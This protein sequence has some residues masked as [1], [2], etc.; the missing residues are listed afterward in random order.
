M[1]AQL[2]PGP[3]RFDRSVRKL[4]K[5]SLGEWDFLNRTALDIAIELE[6][7]NRNNYWKSTS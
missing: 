6:P 2:N 3:F 5:R 7:Q 4:D 1:I